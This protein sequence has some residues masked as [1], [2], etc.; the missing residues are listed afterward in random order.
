VGSSSNA[1]LDAKSG[2]PLKIT[3]LR[4][5][6]ERL[7]GQREE[8]VRQVRETKRALQEEKRE[9]DEAEQARALV[10]LAGK[11]TQEQLQ[12]HLSEL[13]RLAL[14]AIFR[15]P[16]DF[17]IAFETRRGRTEADFWFV[18]DGKRIDPGGN[19]GIGAVDVAG[20]ALRASLWSLRRPRSRASVF[21]DEP[22]PHLKGDEPNRAA[23]EV[24]R[25]ICRPKLE[26]GWPG[27]QLVII[28]DE[29]TSREEL[30][31]VADRMFLIEKQ[32]KESVAR[33]IS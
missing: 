2:I 25:E 17:E 12:Y 23:L 19:C 29:R 3:D 30:K 27:L 15:D 11:M 22:F 21:V 4:H 24:L 28:A 32:G 33:V 31:E 8:L 10:Q 14:S 7:K 5:S 13:A 16:Y 9:A 18:R 20:M 6:L 26:S 1:V